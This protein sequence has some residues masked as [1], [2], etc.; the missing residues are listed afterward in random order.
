M[1]TTHKAK[2]ECS[3]EAYIC[4]IDLSSLGAPW[5]IFLSDSQALRLE[6]S[7]DS[8]EQFYSGKLKFFEA[9]L[10]RQHIYH[11]EFFSG[12]YEETARSNIRRLMTDIKKEYSAQ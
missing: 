10:T 6:H 11:T 12:K 9:L 2:P 1:V 3:D 4:D 7:H 8:D 5:K